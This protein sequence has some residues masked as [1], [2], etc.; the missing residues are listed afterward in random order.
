MIQR[1]AFDYGRTLFNRERNE[2]FPEV[3]AVLTEL[4]KDYSLSIV[5]YS[6][7]DDVDSR[8]AALKELGVWELFE[9]VWFVDRPELKHSALDEMLKRFQL[10]P[11]EVAVVDDYV[12]RGIAWANER[13]ATSIW[14]RNGKFSSLET[15]DEI[16][17]PSFEI[18]N[19]GEILGC[20]TP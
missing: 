15:S 2:F 12:I 10:Q 3:S 5:S 8:T 6:K 11:E 4:S 16:G 9:G 7:P 18:S 19:F 13:G 14:F 17:K 20:L 1:I